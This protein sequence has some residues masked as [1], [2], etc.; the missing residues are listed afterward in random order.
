MILID[1]L[2]E[3]LNRKICLFDKNDCVIAEGRADELFNVLGDYFLNLKVID[4]GEFWVNINIDL[5]GDE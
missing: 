5:R 3:N 4:Y 2:F 1:L